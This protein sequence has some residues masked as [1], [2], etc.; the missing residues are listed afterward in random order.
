MK[1]RLFIPALL[2]AAGCNWGTRPQNF[3]PAWGPGGARVAVRVSGESRDRIGELLA[4]D[5]T[6]VT[7]RASV[8]TFIAWKRLAALDVEGLGRDYDIAYGEPVESDKIARLALVSRFP[9]GIKRLPISLDSLIVDAGRQTQRFADRRIAAAEGYRRIGADF[10]GMGEHWV[11]VALLLGNRID[12]ARPTLLTYATID[13]RPTLLGVGFVVVT[14]GDSTPDVPGWPTEWHEHSGL[15]ADESG[16]VIGPSRNDSQTHVWVMHVWTA[17][18]N[19]AGQLSADN[20]SLPF[21]RAGVAVPRPFDSNAGRGAALAVG[22]D[23]FLRDAL[24]DAALRTPANSAVVDSIIA[25]AR[26]R[27]ASSL[28]AEPDGAALES[29]WVD[30]GAALERAIG[31]EVRAVLVP[32]HDHVHRGERR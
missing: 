1:T 12:P 10:P 13:G 24:T 6:G 28:A 32:A 18:E 17:L 25:S 23:V 11:N 31:P 21:R 22:G 19:P 29:A 4:V 3:P 30:L 26:A 8:V 7:I 16:A 27:A 20:W 2:L 5:S 15:L 14:H 9:Q